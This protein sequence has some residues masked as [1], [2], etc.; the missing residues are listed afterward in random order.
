MWRIS[1]KT[2]FSQ[3][4]GSM[5]FVLETFCVQNLDV[6][7]WHANQPRHLT[8]LSSHQRTLWFHWR[9]H[10]TLYI[11][12]SLSLSLSIQ[13]VAPCYEFKWIFGCPSIFPSREYYAILQNRL[14]VFKFCGRNK[15]M[16]VV[17]LAKAPFSYDLK[18]LLY[19]II[20]Y[21]DNCS[22]T[23]PTSY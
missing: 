23:S 6:N 20:F 2:I 4:A 3:R 15:I 18:Q 5:C 22:T 13:P 21:L 10:A 17:I 8:R 7:L 9:T 1:Q 14:Y 12:F 11:A 19:K 16:K